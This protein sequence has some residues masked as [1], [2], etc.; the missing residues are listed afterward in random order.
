M[1]EENNSGHK[2]LNSYG[3]SINFDT[4][5]DFAMVISS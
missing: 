1:D 5:E 2:G 3:L 4:N